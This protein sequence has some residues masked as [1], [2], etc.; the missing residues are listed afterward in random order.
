MRPEDVSVAAVGEQTLVSVRLGVRERGEETKTG[1][2]KS[3][4]ANRE[5]VAVTLATLK[6]LR[7]GKKRLFSLSRAEYEKEW[8]AAL[9]RPGVG[10]TAE[11]CGGGLGF[12][13]GRS[14]SLG[15]WVGALS[16]AA[17]GCTDDSAGGV[18]GSATQDAADGGALEGV[19]LTD[20]GEL[21]M[22]TDVDISCSAQCSGQQFG[23]DRCGGPCEIG[24][25]SCR[26]RG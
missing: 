19:E 6:Q 21:T 14:R 20:G 4:V 2:D 23:P 9:R 12:G 26:D 7:Q 11:G 3:V 8:N 24:R 15:I 17:M 5:W 25:A 18:A 16:L 13:R 22:P 1:P 10:R